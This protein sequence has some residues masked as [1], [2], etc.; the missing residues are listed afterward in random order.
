MEHL[1]NTAH[2]FS[3][4]ISLCVSLLAAPLLPGIVQRVKAKFA[5]RRGQP[6]LQLYYDL[7]KLLGKGAVYSATTGFLFRASPVAG[8]AS[9]ALALGLTPLAG[10]STLTSLTGDFLWLAGLLALPRFLTITA[11]L[12]TGSSFEGMGASR[13]AHFSALSEPTLLLA[14]ASLG[15]LTH[16]H[17]LAG[18]YGELSANTWADS[19]PVVILTAGALLIAL[20]VENARVPVDDPATHLELT[21]IHEAQIL[22]HGGPDLALIEYTGALRLWIFCALIV[23]LLVPMAREDEVLAFAVFLAGQAAAAVFIGVLESTM[24]RLRMRYVPR[25]IL[26]G[27][28]LALLALLLQLR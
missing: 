25:L 16:R 6:V 28:S 1:L 4:A 19:G 21:M 24:A 10:A 20:L 3:A 26:G 12:D 27:T 7:F 18:M 5:G 2:P 15:M 22:D 11:A 14:L 13:E 8:L 9:L 23:N 17:T